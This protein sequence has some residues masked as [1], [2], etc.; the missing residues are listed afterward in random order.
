M[1]GVSQEMELRCTRL[2]SLSRML[3]AGDGW[4]SSLL[5]VV[6]C[7]AECR[8]ADDPAHVQPPLLKTQTTLLPTNLHGL[9]C[10]EDQIPIRTRQVVFQLLHQHPFTANR[11][12]GLEEQMI[13]I[14]S[15]VG[16]MVGP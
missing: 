2:P 14:T 10:W 3:K 12:H 4:N 1:K 11:I 13:A 8:A 15:P 7:E 16:S 6:L 5:L 9:N